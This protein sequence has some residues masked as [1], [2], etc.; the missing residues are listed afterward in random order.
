[1]STWM[2]EAQSA[3]ED[4][5]TKTGTWITCDGKLSNLEKPEVENPNLKNL[6]VE[7]YTSANDLGRISVSTVDI[8]SVKI[9]EPGQGRCS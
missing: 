7:D 1:M 4:S 5:H 8:D 3:G 6:E 9:R 2:N